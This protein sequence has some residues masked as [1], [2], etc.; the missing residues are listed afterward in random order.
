MSEESAR[1]ADQAIRMLRASEALADV[2]S[3][4][5]RHRNNAAVFIF[6]TALNAF[7]VVFGIVHHIGAV[8]QVVEGVVAG[9]CLALAVVEGRRWRRLVESLRLARVAFQAALGVD[10]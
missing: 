7:F 4:R 6:C 3:Q 8:P 2:E 5:A 1:I 10:Q 9:L